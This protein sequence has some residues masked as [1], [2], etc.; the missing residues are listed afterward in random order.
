MDAQKARA[1]FK[2]VTCINMSDI[3]IYIENASIEEVTEWLIEYFF[4]DSQ[5]EIDEGIFKINCEYQKESF[6]ITVT[7]G[8]EEK[9]TSVWLGKEIKIWSTV[10]SCAVE[11][12]RFLSKTVLCEP[13]E[14][15][16]VPWLFLKISEDQ[17]ELVNI[18]NT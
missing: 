1:H 17:K 7:L 3:E 14:N 11:A 12:S 6:P 13:E 10:T 18:D 5:E 2:G 15:N 9:Y 16:E 4:V 8:V